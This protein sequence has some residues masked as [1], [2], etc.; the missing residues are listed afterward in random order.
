MRLAQVLTAMAATGIATPPSA[1]AQPTTP[2][3]RRLASMVY[4]ATRRELVLFGGL[5]P[6]ASRSFDYPND[7]WAWNGNTW[8][9]IHTGDG[10]PPG[11]EVAHMVYDAA[12]GR[13]VVFGGRRRGSD[14]SNPDLLNDIWEWDGRRWTSIDSS[15]TPALL[16]A[17]TEYDPVHKRVLMY[18]GLNATGFSRSLRAWDGRRWT[19]LDSLGPDGV[20]PAMA[21]VNNNGDFLLVTNKPSGDHD[22]PPDS[23]VTWAWRGGSW[24]RAEHA[25]P[26]ANLQPTASTPGGG[27]YFYQVQERWL[28]APLMHV[29]SSI[30]NW[31]TIKHPPG[32]GYY[33]AA[34]AYDTDR[35]RFVIY[36]VERKSTQLDGETWE[37]DGK[38][39]LK[40]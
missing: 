10:G 30:G 36:G 35:K 19:V 28:S 40:R 18:G 5:A 31:S 12:R 13:V 8:R 37:F 15:D 39:W 1:I 29:R 32:P 6:N 11:R 14:P 22:P 7:L 21:A 16:H 2:G 25:P 3:A 9:R 34:A 17:A 23:S 38:S 33:G 4:D 20:I 24:T 26:L 27:I